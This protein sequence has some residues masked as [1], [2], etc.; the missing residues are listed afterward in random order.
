[1]GLWRT[2]F[3]G[4]WR[5]APAPGRPRPPHLTSNNVAFELNAPEMIRRGGS[6]TGPL[7]P[8][9]GRAEA[10]TVGAVKRARDLVCATLGTL[11]IRLHDSTR[12]AIRSDLLEQ[13]ESDV[14]RSVTMTRIAEDMLF[15][16]V[17]WLRITEF[18]WHGF[19]TKV[20]RLEPRSVTVRTDARVYVSSEDGRP[21]GIA[22]E[23]VPD[24]ELIRIDSP[25]E[26]L[27]KSAARAIRMAIA[28]DQA[29]ERYTRDPLPLGYFSPA[30]GMADQDPN[31]IQPLLDEWETARSERSW[32]YIGAALKANV[33]Q[34]DP[35]KLQLASSRNAIVLEIARHAGVDPEDLGV[36][37]TSRTYANAEQ[38]RLDLVDFTLAAYVG[39]I[40]TRLSMPDVVPGGHLVRFDYAGFLRS[41]TKTRMETYKVGRE[42]GVYNDQRIAEIENIPSAVPQP[43]PKPAPRPADTPDEETTVQQSAPR[44][45]RVAPAPAHVPSAQFAS[46]ET[47]T[48]L[49]TFT[50]GGDAVA[51]QFAV[52]SAKRTITGLAVPWNMIARSGWALWKFPPDSLVWSDVSRV[53]MFRDHDYDQAVGVATSLQSTDAG[54]VATLKVARGAE[55]DT[56]LTLAEDGVLDGLSIGVWFDGESDDWQPDPA[57]ERVRL[58]RRASLREV[59][60]T[61]MP[62]F[63][64][65]R[66]TSVTASQTSP[67]A[68]APTAKENS[69]MTAPA[70][71]QQPA[72]APAAPAAPAAGTTAAPAAP[73][74][75]VQ[76]SAPTVDMA[77]FT[78]G[79]SE[80]VATAVAEAFAKLPFQQQHE[81]QVVPA[82]RAVVTQE[83]PVYSMNGYG[84]SLVRDSWRAHREYDS[85]ARE[86]LRK[87]EAQT[88]DIAKQAASVM[89]AANTTNAAAVI[90]PGYRPDLYVTQL[91]RGR[92][93]V[94]GVSRGALEDATPFTIP[95]FTSASG[96]SSQHTEG[97]NPSPGTLELDVVTVTPRAISGTFQLT[98][99]IVDSS[100]PAIDAIAMQAMG[101]SYSQQ[102]E[103]MVYAEVNGANGQGGPIT[104]GFT[105]SG[106]QASATTGGSA[107]EGTFGGRELIAGIRGAEA[108]YPFRRFA[109]PT[110]GYLSQEG[111]SAL[112]TAVD[113][114]GRPLLPPANPSNSA[115]TGV[116][117]QAWV[118]DNLVFEPCWSMTGN[119]AGDADALM[120][121]QA[122]VWAWESGLLTFRYE[123]RN[124]PANVDLAL[125]GYFASRVLRPVGLS[126]VRHTRG[127]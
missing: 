3:G 93:L 18:G 45:L 76:A 30:E 23:H 78:A 11:P 21:Q 116:A 108:L 49:Q 120:F 50:F 90:P 94:N 71:E 22:E 85:E 126:A 114:D 44:P 99:E 127:E 46:T 47:G 54:L 106:A 115:G 36:S 37:T 31:E 97:T 98:R 24:A 74:A 28:L 101:E 125:F 1:M 84:H 69:T 12:N 77:Q 5:D 61:P 6:T 34:W 119:A 14:A 100:N 122:D 55:G 107:A 53:K 51:A 113:N 38:R 66:I 111:T 33:L 40:E 67:G 80:A 62:S 118:I 70:P 92:P 39:A 42:V 17:S 63:D 102:T 73:A 4:G 7:A 96:M 29:T 82:G 60:I 88:D 2:V 64:T 56:I 16:G 95:S 43:P 25:N 105:P 65:A 72:A 104:A 123:E 10:L 87:F 41:D 75:P 35:E 124:G 112:A 26:P 8:R 68:S 83:A 32:G 13:P 52:D 117:G 27:L 81:R 86:R 103:G 57:D 89:F 91:M 109:G 58:V 48:A 19:P 9:V 15:E 79:M 20:R 121:N 59:S 110:R